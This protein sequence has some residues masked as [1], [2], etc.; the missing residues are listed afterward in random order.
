MVVLVPATTTLKLLPETCS[1]GSEK[2]AWN[3]PVS[4]AE[5]VGDFVVTCGAVPSIVT[6]RTADVAITLLFASMTSTR[7]KS[8]PSGIEVV[9][10]Q[11]DI[12]VVLLA[13]K[14]ANPA[15][16]LSSHLYCTARGTLVQV[17][18]AF[19]DS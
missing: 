4:G 2:L 12:A 13:A 11:A 5:L 19:P 8:P 17:N 14:V 6:D 9:G 3:A 10:A 15:D 16:L 7:Q 1:T 18:S